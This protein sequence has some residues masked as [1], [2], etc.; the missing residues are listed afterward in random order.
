M[1]ALVLGLGMMSWGIRSLLKNEAP[2]LPADADEHG[3][4]WMCPPSLNEILWVKG[5]PLKPGSYAV[6]LIGLAVM[7]RSAVVLMFM[8]RE[9]RLRT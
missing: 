9:R 5:P 1:T 6:S 3:G 7:Y 2:P 8:L 4:P